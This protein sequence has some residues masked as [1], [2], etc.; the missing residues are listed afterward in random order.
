MYPAKAVLTR[1]RS[2]AWCVRPP[3]LAGDGV[4]I[5]FY[6]R[7]SDDDDELALAPGRFREQ[8][9]CL[10]AEGYRGVD[11]MTL[12]RELREGRVQE[13]T[14]GLT[15]DDGYLDVAENALPP[16]A[17]HGFGATVFVAPAVMDG[18]VVYSWYR[19]QPPLIP[20]DDLVALDRESALRFEAHTLTHPNLLALDE[21]R[22]REEIVGS[23]SVLGERLGRPV[24][25]FC[26]PAGLFGDRE[27]RIVAESGFRAAVSCEPGV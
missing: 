8:M 22:A 15:F 11:V 9:A 7:V 1:A 5:L 26:Y 2:L 13:R 25:V 23:R 20:W 19:R 16:L 24:D 27:R 6:H 21:E 3:R 14:I 4:R 10:A 17:E 12:V 18:E